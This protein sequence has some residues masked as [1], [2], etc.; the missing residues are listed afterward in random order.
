MIYFVVVAL[1]VVLRICS[2]F[3]VFEFL[4]DFASSILGIVTQVGLIFLLPFF[5][6]KSL[7]KMSV[8][9]TCKFFSFKKVSIK[10]VLVSIVLGVVVFCLNVYVSSFF[11]G[12][13]QM[14]G[15][16]PAAHSSS[17]SK[18]WWGLL[19]NLFVSAVLPAICEESLHRGMLL[20]GNSALG[21]KKSILLS[22]LL[23]GLLHLNIEQF[24]Y[25]AIIGFFLGYL[26]WSCNSIYPCIIIHFMNNAISVFLSFASANGCAIG[27]IFTEVSKFLIQSQFLGLVMFLL[28]L[29]LLVV[30]A[31]DLTKL[32][33]KDS[34]DYN[35]GK[36][37]KELAN[38]AVR[39]NFFKQIDDIKNDTASDPLYSAEKNVLYIDLAEFMQY[40][41]KSMEIV[42]SK[43]EEE[44]KLHPEVEDKNIDLKIKILK[45]GSIALS[46][47][48]T[49]MTFIWGFFR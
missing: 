49:I 8:K 35:F 3:G 7:N 44:E 13:I 26:C 27:N 43:Q 28:V 29:G 17:V 33:M 9:E 10:T 30:F 23:F 15:Y 41:N 16:T 46:A 31:I 32:L 25:A 12:I 24:F 1:F 39:E 11:N 45:Y 20:K 5:L 38:M 48:V 34:F 14:F 19:L 47:I 21:M 18:E 40:V 6:F 37:Q 42:K 36:K 4:G 2:N 22:G